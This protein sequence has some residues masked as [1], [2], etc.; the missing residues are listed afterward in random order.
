MAA[1]KK[2]EAEMTDSW[3]RKVEVFSMSM[4]SREKSLSG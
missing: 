2:S 4:T 3:T 1:L